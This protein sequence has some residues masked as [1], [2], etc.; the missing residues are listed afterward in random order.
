MA[1]PVGEVGGYSREH[2]PDRALQVYDARAGG[3]DTLRVDHRKSRL[4]RRRGDPSGAASD[5]G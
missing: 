5:H 2:E 3:V 4:R 1:A